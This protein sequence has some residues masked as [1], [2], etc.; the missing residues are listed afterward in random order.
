MDARFSKSGKGEIYIDD[1]ALIGDISKKQRY[2]IQPM[3]N[4][5]AVLPGQ[6]V[7]REYLVRNG[8]NK[9]ADATVKLE[10]YN[11]NDVKVFSSSK[12]LVVSPNGCSNISLDAGKLSE[13][14]YYTK[15]SVTCDN[16]TNGYTGWFGVYQPNNKRQNTKPMY[17]GVQDTHHLERFL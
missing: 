6:N 8:S 13:G 1:I 10:V 17:F 9:K 3:Y 15:V 12:Q 4:G 5:I 14:A 2:T 16:T 7:V 11:Y